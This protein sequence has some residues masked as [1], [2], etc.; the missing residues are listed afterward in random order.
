VSDQELLRKL[1]LMLLPEDTEKFES[2]RESV[3]SFLDEIE[4]SNSELGR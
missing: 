4:E 3:L 1:L 2:E